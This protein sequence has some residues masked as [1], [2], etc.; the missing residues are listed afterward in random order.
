MPPYTQSCDC[1]GIHRESVA[2]DIA[3]RRR[4]L[5]NPMLRTRA[6]ARK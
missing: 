6:D 1:N 4:A 5:A 2:L 3:I